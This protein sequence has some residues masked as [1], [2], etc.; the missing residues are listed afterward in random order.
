MISDQ[1]FAEEHI[2]SVPPG[3]VPDGVTGD[4]HVYAF[5]EDSQGKTRFVWDGAVGEPFDGVVA[6]RDGSSTFWSDDGRHFAYVGE[7]AGQG[8][9][10]HDGRE[11]PP[12]ETVSGSIP[13]TF[14]ADGSRLVYGIVEKG[15]GRLIIDGQRVGGEVLAPIAVVFS[16]N[17]EHLA[18]V[19]MRG[20]GDPEQRVVIDSVG[21]PWFRG[22]RNARGVMQ[23]SPDGRRFAYYR[24][25][26]K[27]RGQWILDDVEQPWASDVQPIGFAQMRGVGVLDEPM[28][29]CFSPDGSRFAYAADVDGKGVAMIEGGDVGPRVKTCGFPIFS[30][31][32]E[33]LAYSTETLD[34]RNAVVLDGKVGPPMAGVLQLPV[35][36]PDNRQIAV[37]HRREEGGLFRKRY[38]H[39]LSIDNEV[40]DEH[41]AI[42]CSLQPAFSPDGS[43]VA[44]WVAPNKE[45]SDLYV[46]GERESV[47]RTSSDPFFTESGALVFAAVVADGM[48]PSVDGRIGP[49]AHGFLQPAGEVPLAL[50]DSQPPFRISPVGD[51]VAWAGV[52][53]DA[54]G[55][56]DVS[57]MGASPRPVLDDLVGPAFD[58]VINFRFEEDGRV[59]WWAQRGDA[60]VRV[61]S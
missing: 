32:S 36:S 57:S 15:A 33:H 3:C 12:V 26:G 25:D 38:V 21:G 10:G 45:V 1:Q 51:H 37:T 24:V 6:M 17:G 7:R 23:F 29:A 55:H 22:M 48:A 18:W 43:R 31:D 4:G 44:W 54:R 8:F 13:P 59:I 46:V 16:Q 49:R 52:F 27:G 9:V 39:A 53:S 58:Q 42:D 5:W 30:S 56:V 61:S 2:H 41:E 47:G 35:F 34:K 50:R 11:D 60:I 19:E 20:P 14:S 28:Y 40:M